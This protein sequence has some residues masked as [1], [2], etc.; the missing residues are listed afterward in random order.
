MRAGTRMVLA[1]L[2]SLLAL[3]VVVAPASAAGGA[4]CGIGVNGLIADRYAQLGNHWGVLGCPTGWA[5]SVYPSGEEQWFQ[6]GTIAWS[7]GTGNCSVQAAW[8][9]NGRI[10]L[11]W[12]VT[13]PYHYDTW[14]V[15][16]DRGGSNLG[17]PEYWNGSPGVWANHGRVQLPDYGSGFF[18][19]II[20]GCDYDGSHTC[21][22]PWSNP[23]YVG[24]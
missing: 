20:K 2:L 21:D 10:W 16:I 7:P 6:H 1:A 9:E 18:Q 11:D 13:D 24:I 19:I 23:V 14:L 22:Q 4:Y 3:G 8:L 15:R 12:G 17:Q 5:H